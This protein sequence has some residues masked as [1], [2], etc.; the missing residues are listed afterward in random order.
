MRYSEKAGEILGDV[1][2]F[3]KI[4]GKSLRLL[5]V[6]QSKSEDALLLEVVRKQLQQ[7]ARIVL[8]IAV[9]VG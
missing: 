3:S 6:F 9:D 5:E 1:G 8:V 7:V 2:G 4:H